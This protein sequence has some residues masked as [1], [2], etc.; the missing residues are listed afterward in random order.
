MELARQDPAVLAGSTGLF[1]GVAYTVEG[2]TVESERIR[3]SVDPFAVFEDWCQMQTPVQEIDITPVSYRCG[4]PSGASLQDG[5]CVA[6]WVV[7][8]P[9]VPIDCFMLDCGSR[10]A[11]DSSSCHAKKEDS[12]ISVDAALSDD[13]QELVGTILIGGEARTIRLER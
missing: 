4:P 7:G 12:P 1:E 9:G 11:C 2:S 3:F 5:S 10:C 13:G 8:E 6:Y